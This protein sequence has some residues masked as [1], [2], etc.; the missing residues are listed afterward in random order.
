[1]NKRE[2]TFHP[3]DSSTANRYLWNFGDG[4]TDTSVAPL[5]KYLRDSLYHVSLQVSNANHCVATFSDTVR[6]NTTAISPL[7]FPELKLTLYPNPAQQSL[8]ITC[9]GNDCN[10]KLHFYM[11]NMEGRIVKGAFFKG[12]TSYIVDVSLLKPG[13]Y[14]V[15][16]G[17]GQNVYTK[18]II[19]Q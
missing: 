17:S 1:L 18:T 14:L 13:S 11:T 19:K 3:A 6:I 2:T 15:H 8:N 10:H 12:E 9:N 16:I 4:T 7:V 5:H